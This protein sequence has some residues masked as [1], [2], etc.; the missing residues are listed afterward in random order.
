MLACGGCATAVP[1]VAGAAGSTPVVGQYL[2]QGEADSF[3]IARYDDVVQATLRAG[4]TL[5]LE[6]DHK[7]VGEDHA[8]LH[9][10]DDQDQEIVLIIER[11]TETVTRVHFDAGSQEFVGFARLL[12][13]QIIQE[14]KDAD[15][16]LVNWS[17]INPSIPK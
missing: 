4:E 10:S 14:L 5:S 1:I 6:V 12:A 15:A 2:V 16:F 11:R 8:E 17:D 7:E 3:W 13:R 9:F